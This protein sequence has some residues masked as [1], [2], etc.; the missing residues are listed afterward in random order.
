MKK[1]AGRKSIPD[2]DKKVTAGIW[3][4]KK[5]KAKIKPMLDVIIKTFDK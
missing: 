1:R 3:V 4:R 5:N 2:E